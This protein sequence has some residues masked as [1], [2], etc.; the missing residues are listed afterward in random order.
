[1]SAKGNWI[2][3]QANPT[4]MKTMLLPAEFLHT[5]TCW[6]SHL[7]VP[8]S[9]GLEISKASVKAEEK[10]YPSVICAVR[11]AFCFL[12]CATHKVTNCEICC[13]RCHWNRQEISFE[14][15]RQIFSC[16]GKCKYLLCFATFALGSGAGIRDW[17]SRHG[18]S[19]GMRQKRAENH[20]VR[21]RHWILNEDP[22]EASCG[23]ND[24]F[25]KMQGGRFTTK[26]NIKQI[27]LKI[28]L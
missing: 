12:R 25:I 5:R 14:F 19:R 22:V 18:G 16:R 8:L 24:M 13:C 26:K 21:I 17:H 27:I 28:N 7:Y 15:A 1:M 10:Q 23:D 20:A 2:V 11:C 6:E 3:S 9:Y 4:Q